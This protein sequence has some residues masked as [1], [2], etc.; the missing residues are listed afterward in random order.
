M[1]AAQEERFTRVKHDDALPGQR[2]PLLPARRRRRRATARRGRL[3]RQADH[4]PSCGCCGPT[5]ASGPAGFASFQQAMP[6]WLRKKLWI[7]LPDRA[8]AAR[9]RL[10]ACP[11]SLLFTE[12]HE[13]HAASAFFP[14]P[15]ESAAVLTF[16]GVGEWATSSIGV[17]EGNRITL[18]RQLF[19]PNS[20]GLLYSAFTYSLRL[21]RQLRRVQADGPGALRRAA[22]RRP[23]PRRAA[24][25]A[26][27][28]LVPHEHALLRLPE[29][30]ED[31]QL[32]LRSALRR[33]GARARER[34]HQARDGPGH[35][36]SRR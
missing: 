11:T 35:A 19:F 1:A 14:S 18:E 28:R 12:H 9:A 20:I 6:L 10:R 22:L 2:D 24:R 15:F 5:C 30:A 25:P 8:R 3:L 26:R 27:G 17:G 23:H 33:A 13:S 32:A 7:P 21:P 16:D 34:D 29:R 31:D 36:R 4:A